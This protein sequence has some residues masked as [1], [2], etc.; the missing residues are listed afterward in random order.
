MKRLLLI[1]LTVFCGM[2]LY[3]QRTISGKITDGDTG[4]GLPGVTIQVKGTTS[5]A[6]TDLDGNYTMSVADGATLVISYVGF[7]TQEI[8]IGGRT[9]IDIVLQADVGLLNEVVVIGY[10]ETT[11][12]D[13]TG[14]VASVSSEDFNGGMI[15]SPEQLIQGKTAGVQM[16]SVSGNPGD[17]VQL[18]IR[19]T[20]SVRS[21][22]NPLFVVDGVPLSGGVT[23]SP[24]IGDVGTTSDANPL[25]FINPADIASVSILKDASATAIYGSRGANGVVIITTKS[26]KGKGTKLDY[27]GSVS[28]ATPAA[29][30]DLLDGP[31]FVSAAVAA[32]GQEAEINRGSNTDWQDVITRTSLSTKHNLAYTANFGGNTTLRTSFGYE[33]QEGILEN[34]N[35]ERITGRINGSR[36]FLNDRLNVNLTSTFSRVNREDPPISGSAGFRGDILGAAYIANPTWSDDPNIEQSELGGSISPANY[37]ANYRSTANSNRLLANLS[38]DYELTNDVRVKATY[39]ADFSDADRFA[40]LT[41]NA[42]NLGQGIQGFGQGGINNNKSFSNLFELTATYNKSFGDLDVEVLAGYSVQSFR[43]WGYFG[44]AYGFNAGDGLDSMQDELESSFDAAES[45]ANGIY[46]EGEYAQ[47]GFSDDVRGNDLSGNA[48]P[49]GTTGFVN[50]IN[51]ESFETTYAARTAGIGVDAITANYFDNTDYLQ[52]YFGRGNFTYKGKYLLTVTVR[53]DGSSKFGEDER[54]GVFPSFAAGW[55]LSEE[56]FI[57]DAFSSLKLRAG[58]GITG[59]QDG[60]TYG[61]FVRRERWADVNPDAAQ[62]FIN[63][64]GTATQGDPNPQL[65]WEQ[66]VQTA[67]GLDFGFN[68]ERIRGTF[69]WYLK[70]TEDLLLNVQVAQP[71]L[72]TQRFENLSDGIVENRGWELT[73]GYDLIDNGNV[74]FSID[75]N[76]ANN[77]NELKDFGGQLNAGQIRGQG[78]SGA[79]AQALAG[80]RPLFSYFLREFEGFD[81]DGQ[82]IGDVQRFIGK[83]ALPEW[84]AG[85]SL[86]LEIGNFDWTAYLTGQFGHYIYNNTENA[87]FTAGSLSSGRNV[88]TDVV[89]NGESVNA[90][91]SVSTRFLSPGDFVRMQSMT[92]GYNVPMDGNTVI[93]NL[94]V[95]FNMQNLFL[96]TDY[97]GL[98][99]EI[100]VNPSNFDLLNG[101]PTAG[102]DL[103]AYPRPR[104]FTLGV[105]ATF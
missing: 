83:S 37:L 29:E 82:P 104:T 49:D 66:T 102:I 59:N 58:W 27:S 25:N 32:G 45:I 78:L 12:K 86:N 81:S 17:G 21:N 77:K 52:S 57:P 79:F 4:E 53:A 54:Y 50:R 74:L 61:Q 16:T 101:L 73:L 40:L 34:S 67:V 70:E 6:S 15:G 13:A 65:R 35:M 90:A 80:G 92:F 99:P 44:T 88:T 96:I 72:A 11:V 14:A 7:E 42:F 9:T 55:Q 98:D 19:G 62:R 38:V 8:A 31:A 71:A 63:F 76:I 48:V 56:S 75:G 30:Y 64:P 23:A 85:L 68:N 20:N 84:N 36:S 1:M 3:A 33:N 24:N 43:N 69:D 2:Q 18:R 28:I 60:L 10:G 89:G 91:A 5:G 95:T 105:N 93:R 87:F 41:P 26:G 103:T 22:N 46:G 100:S 97:S 39:G 51:G 47:W 94:R